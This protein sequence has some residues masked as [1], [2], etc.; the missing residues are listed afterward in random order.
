MLNPYRYFF[1]TALMSYRCASWARVAMHRAQTSAFSLLTVAIG[2][3]LVTC[4]SSDETLWASYLVVPLR[5]DDASK[6][7]S[8]VLFVLVLAESGRVCKWPS[9]WRLEMGLVSSNS[10][11]HVFI[12]VCGVPVTVVCMYMC[13]KLFICTSTSVPSIRLNVNNHLKQK[14][15]SFSLELN[16]FKEY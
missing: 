11:A 10:C 16:V 4:V 3:V 14:K 6:P 15:C 7:V 12:C 2:C 13:T 8:V 1:P 9:L 5:K